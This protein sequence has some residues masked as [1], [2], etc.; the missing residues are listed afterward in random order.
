MQGFGVCR[1]AEPDRFNDVF[2]GEIDE[3]DL[4]FLRLA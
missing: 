4:A 2:Q 3:A 1:V